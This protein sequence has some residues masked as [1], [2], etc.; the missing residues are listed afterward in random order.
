[1]YVIK[2]TDQGRGYVTPP[3]S[4]HS[5]TRDLR[6]ARTFTTKEAANRERCEG[7]EISVPLETELQSPSKG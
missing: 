5:Y 6:E 7:N 1:M 4:A 2:R 3:G